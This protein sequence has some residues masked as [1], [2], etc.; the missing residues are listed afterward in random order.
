V[1]SLFAKLGLYYSVV[2]EMMFL[3]LILRDHAW[4]EYC[5]TWKVELRFNPQFFKIMG[6]YFA[7]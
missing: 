3:E 5:I 7:S 6:F 1:A 2:G 4:A